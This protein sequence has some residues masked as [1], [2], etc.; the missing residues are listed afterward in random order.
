MSTEDG[1]HEMDKMLMGFQRHATTSLR[2][3][4]RLG[5][6]LNKEFQQLFFQLS[7]DR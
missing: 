6:P 2:N 5:Q 1:K 7:N 3:M 4:K